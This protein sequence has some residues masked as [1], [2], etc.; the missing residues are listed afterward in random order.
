MEISETSFW[1][2]AKESGPIEWKSET[3]VYKYLL[4]TTGM[5]RYSYSI[6]IEIALG[7][8]LRVEHKEC[9]PYYWETLRLGLW[10]DQHVLQRLQVIPCRAF[11]WGGTDVT[12]FQVLETIRVFLFVLSFSIP[13]SFSPSFPLSLFLSFRSFLHLEN[14][15]LGDKTGFET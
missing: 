9:R 5:F 13:L 12:R 6:F 3:S 8:G 14:S 4:N 11:F 1:G 2:N 7:F 10:R 15:A